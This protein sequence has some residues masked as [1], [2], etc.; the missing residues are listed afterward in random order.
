VVLDYAL[1]ERDRLTEFRRM[2]G[3][4]LFAVEDDHDL[5]GLTSFRPSI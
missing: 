2:P 5:I 1:R 3:I 4:L